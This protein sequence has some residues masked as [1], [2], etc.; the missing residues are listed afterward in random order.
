MS[1][2]KKIEAE[3]PEISDRAN[4]LRKKVAAWADDL[5]G[6]QKVDY[7][8]NRERQI[9]ALEEKYDELLQLELW[10]NPELD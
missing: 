8:E 9:E 1:D 2:E 5:R 3:E 6:R 10:T 4:D 7:D